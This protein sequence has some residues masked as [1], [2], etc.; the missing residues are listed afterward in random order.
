MEDLINSEHFKKLMDF[1]QAEVDQNKN[2][3]NITN[4]KKDNEDNEENKENAENED[5]EDNGKNNIIKNKKF[6][7]FCEEL[8]N[9]INDTLK[10]IDEDYKN[11]LDKQNKKNSSNNK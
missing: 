6:S 9:E 10:I 2:N 5:N 3:D 8:R 4:D 11:T 7:S 1:Y